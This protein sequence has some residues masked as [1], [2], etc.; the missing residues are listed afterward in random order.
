M[1]AWGQGIEG[2]ARGLAVDLAPIRVNLVKLGAVHTELFGDIPA[3]RL[4][5]VLEKMRKN[6]LTGTV[7]RPEEVAEM[8][9]GL[10]KCAFV[11][12]SVVGVDGGRLLA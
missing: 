1:A 2:I 3:E 12:G 10:M 7:G 9:L 5:N 8:Y 6:T 4:E 11:T